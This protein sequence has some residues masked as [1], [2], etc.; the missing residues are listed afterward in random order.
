[1]FDFDDDNA[2]LFTK[3]FEPSLISPVPPRPSNGQIDE[4]TLPVPN[5]QSSFFE[6]SW[7]PVLNPYPMMGSTSNAAW[8]RGFPLDRITSSDTFSASRKPD[9]VPFDQ[10]CL[11]LVYFSTGGGL[12]DAFTRSQ[13]GSPLRTT[14]RTSMPFTVSPR[15][16]PPLTFCVPNIDL[17]LDTAHVALRLSPGRTTSCRPTR[18]LRA[19]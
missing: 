1:M 15:C 8:P 11:T 4:A 19:I 3:D 18:N 6:I 13:F 14:T 10:A 2:L 16:T 5:R 9:S 12:H 7:P 17:P